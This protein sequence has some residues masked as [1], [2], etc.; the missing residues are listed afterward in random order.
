MKKANIKQPMTNLQL[1]MLKLFSLDLDEHDLIT[2][3]RLIV[4]YLAEKISD[5]ADQVWEDNKWSDEAMERL[6]NTHQRT[7][8]NSQS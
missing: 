1:E 8:Y 2:I 7:P 3:K 6:L 4:K 5:M